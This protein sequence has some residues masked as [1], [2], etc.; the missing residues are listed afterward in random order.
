VWCKRTCTLYG[1]ESFADTVY[2][3]TYYWNCCWPE[4]R[5]IMHAC[6]S[7]WMRHWATLQPPGGKS[8]NHQMPRRAVFSR[9]MT[10][11]DAATL[12]WA[13]VRGACPPGR[14]SAVTANS[15]PHVG[16]PWSL[17][18]ASGVESLVFS[19]IRCIGTWR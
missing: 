10:G 7:S 9:S 6:T 18:L 14:P 8:D 3:W 15:R 4:D 19:E 2:R 11:L 13:P 12:F 5:I 17:D 1:G 16:T